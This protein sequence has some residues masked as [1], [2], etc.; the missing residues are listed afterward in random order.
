VSGPV[1]LLGGAGFIGGHVAAALL[2]AGRRVRI[3][4]RPGRRPLA[5]PALRERAE[6]CEGDFVNERDLAPALAGCDAAVHLVSTT[7]PQSA[8]A[9]PLYDLETNVGGTLRLLELARR[10]PLR[11][12]LFVSSGGTVYGVPRALPI[13]ESHPT[14]PISAYGIGKLAIEKYLHLYRHLHGLDSLVLRLANPYG[15]RQPPEA[16]Q[17]AVAVFLRRA[18]AGQP[19]EIWG[20]GSVARDYVY[21][22]D[23]AEAL[24]AALDY[25]GGERV[26]NVG[27]GVA[28][29]LNELVAAIEAELGR[30]VERRHLAARAID[31]PVNRLDVTLAARE[32]GWTPRTPFATGLARARRWLE[33]R[34]TPAPI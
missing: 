5:E 25:R 24:L 20:D 11:R 28:M 12:L 19:I 27:S 30:P 2:A 18:L 26:F 4:D 10:V 8:T 34:A 29:T 15:E 22:G 6:W 23:V 16:A 31:V 21:V 7:L 33:S 1:L 9:N 14:E 13:A 32:L 3:F 17:G